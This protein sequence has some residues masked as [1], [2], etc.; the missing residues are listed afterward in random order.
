MPAA[1]AAGDFNGGALD[2]VT[3]NAGSNDFSFLSGNGDGTFAAATS[4]QIAG[5]QTLALADTPTDVAAGLLDAGSTPDLAVSGFT[6]NSGA[7]TILFG[8]GDTTFGSPMVRGV[9]G[10]L[11]SVVIGDFHSA[12]GNDIAVADA[13]NN[14]IAILLNDGAGVFGTPSTIAV[15][16]MPV[17]LLTANFD[18]GATLD[19]VAA[20]LDSNNFSV[21]LGN[22]DGTFA[23]AVA[24][25]IGQTNSISLADTPTDLAAGL[26][27]GDAN[28]DLVV[29]GFATLTGRVAVLLGNGDFTFDPAIN[30]IVGVRP[31]SLVLGDF[32][33][34]TLTDVALTDSAADRIRVLD[35][36]GDGS[37]GA[38]TSFGVGVMPTGIVAGLFDAGSVL[39]LAAVNTGGNN[40]SVALGNP[41]AA[42]GFAPATSTT[43]ASSAAVAIGFTPT[44]L[45][46][47]NLDDGSATDLAVV[48]FTGGTGRLGVFLGNGDT[49][50]AAPLVTDVG[51]RL[52]SVVIGDF[53]PDNKNDLAVTDADNNAILILLG[54][55]D[56][57][58]GFDAPSSYAVGA[59][60]VALVSG[61]FNTGSVLDLLAVNHGSGDVSAIFGNNDGTFR[62]LQNTS[63]NITLALGFTPMSLAAT[64]PDGAQVDFNG[65]DEFDLA[66]TGFSG[67]SGRLAIALGDGNGAFMLQ[68]PL[69][70]I[71]NSAQLSDVLIADFDS[72]GKADVAVT[73]SPNNPLSPDSS[74]NRINVL[75][76]NG[77]GT[78]DSPET[79]NVGG[80][81][82]GLVVASFNEKDDSAPDLAVVNTFDSSISIVLGS[83]TGKP[84]VA[85]GEFGSATTFDILRVMAGSDGG[86]ISKVTIVNDT[87]GYSIITGRGGDSPGPSSA[88]G[89]AITR[90]V[91]KAGTGD[92]TMLTG[93]GGISNRGIAE[94]GGNISKVSLT[95]AGSYTLRTGA[96]GFGVGSGGDGGNILSV[97]IDNATFTNT[98]KAISLTTGAGGVGQFGFGGD[99]GIVSKVTLRGSQDIGIVTGSGN[100]GLLGGGVAGEVKSVTATAFDDIFV[101]AGS[102]GAGTGA[103]S[104]EDVRDAD[105]GVGGTISRSTFEAVGTISLT[106]GT[107]GTGRTGGG[108]GG[109]VNDVTLRSGRSSNVTAGAGGVGD[110][111]GGNGGRVDRLTVLQAEDLIVIGGDGADASNAGGFGGDVT[112][113]TG[114]ITSGERSALV[115]GDGGSGSTGSH[116][117][118]VSSIEIVGNVLALLGGNGGQGGVIFPT[119]VL[120]GDFNADGKTDLLSVNNS[121]ST[122]SILFGSGKGSFGKST[123]LSVITDP[124][125]DDLPQPV[126]AASGDFNRDG[127]NDIAVANLGTDDLSI[128]LSRGKGKFD[129]PFTV[130]VGTAPDAIA[131]TDLNSDG[132]VDLAVANHDS[133][134]VTVLLG[135]GRGNFDQSASPG[136][137]AA[138]DFN[139]DTFTDL[140]VANSNLN[141][142]MLFLGNGSG[143]F[144]YERGLPVGA[145]PSALATGDFNADGKLDFAVANRGSDNV[146]VLL[147]NNDGTFAAPATF[148]VGDAPS[149]LVAGNFGGSAAPDLAVAN[150]GSDTV[151]I[152]INNG[153]GSF[154]SATHHAVG[155]NPVA[156]VAG[157]FDGDTRLDLATANDG[158]IATGLSVLHANASG[159]FDPPVSTLLAFDPLALTTGLLNADADLDLVV[160]GFQNTTGK[161]AVLLGA[162]GSTFDAPSI[163]DIG[164]RISSVALAD[165]NAD[166]FLDIVATNS[167]TNRAQ[168]LLGVGDGT[169]GMTTAFIV[170]S[171]PVGIVTGLF[172]ASTNVDIA[173]INANSNNFSVLLGNGNGTLG[174]ASNTTLFLSRSTVSVGNGPVDVQPGDFDGDGVLDL[175]TANDEADNISFLKGRGNGTFDAATNTALVT[176]A[177]ATDLT[178]A[179]VNDDDKLDAV[180][181]AFTETGGA[182]AGQ[183]EVFLGNGNGTFVAPS[184]VAIAG[185]GTPNQLIA[186]DVTG[187]G[188]P[189][190]AV[191]DPQVNN[192]VILRGDNTGAFETYTNGTVYV[193]RQPVSLAVADLNGDGR[194][195]V[196]TADQLDGKLSVALNVDGG[197]FQT[198]TAVALFRAPAGGAGGSVN[199]VEVLGTIGD[200]VD[201]DPVATATGDFNNDMAA[202]LVVIGSTGEVSVFFGDGQ[203]GFSLS[204]SLVAGANPVAVLVAD[205]T[206]DSRPD[207]VVA[208][209]DSD[210]VSIF[211]N[212]GNGGFSGPTNVAVGQA[213]TALVAGNFG[214]STALDL[215]VTVSG[216][217]AVTI[218]LNNGDGT[219]DL[220]PLAVATGD[221]NGDTFLDLLIANSQGN[222]LSLFLGEADGGFAFQSAI[223]TGEQPS[224]VV[225]GNFGGSAALDVAVVNRDDDNVSVLIGNGDGT[226]GPGTNFTVG[227][228]PVALVAGNFGGDARLDLAVLNSGADNVSILINDGLGSFGAATH[229]AAG[230]NPVAITTADLDADSDAD[231]AV[232]NSNSKTI[233]IL[234]GDGS[235]MFTAGTSVV[236]DD[237]PLAIAAGLLDD[238]G[239]VDLAV[240]GFTSTT[241]KLIVLLGNGNAT[242]ANPSVMDAGRRL[243][244]MTIAD[245][246]G[247]GVNDI[248]ATDSA[249]NQVQ[250]LLGDGDGGFDGAPVDVGSAPQAVVAGVF[251]TDGEMDLVAINQTND[252]FST[253]LGRGDGTFEPAVNT[254]IRGHSMFEIGPDPVAIVTG[255]L[256]GDTRLDLVTASGSASS[257]SVLLGD[258]KGGFGA[259][260]TIALANNLRGLAIGSLDIGT[261]LDLVVT[262]FA[263]GAGKLTV[264]LGN[265]DGTFGT[266]TTTNVGTNL[267]PVQ[268]DTFD[269]NTSLDVA[270][271]DGGQVSVLLGNGDGTFGLATSYNVGTTPVD[272]VTGT[273]NSDTNKDILTVN[274]GSQDTTALLGAGNGTFTMTATTRLSQYGF[275]FGR[276]GGIAAGL[277]GSSASLKAALNGS[278]T[279][280]EAA[281]IAAI[282]AGSGAT[283][284][285]ATSVDKIETTGSGITIGRDFN[286]NG[287]YN[288]VDQNPPGNGVPDL[289]DTPIDGFILAKA[290]GSINGQRLD[291]MSP[292]EELLFALIVQNDLNPNNDVRVGEYEAN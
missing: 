72:D 174:A 56:A 240:A 151:S 117:G 30:T 116:G 147:G 227:D 234:L 155:D 82:R 158:T 292:P 200:Y 239:T 29:S 130:N 266:P 64:L 42:S 78:F 224:G 223:A 65:D 22:G 94:D 92:V 5:S 95:G 9:G 73:V 43:I 186:G 127:N 291:P 267:G 57:A 257:L 274:A 16:T 264:L 153:S 236:L 183:V 150:S 208:N 192:F 96:G 199:G 41:D 171:T 194:L 7:L 283:P 18:G 176:G 217:D 242:Y 140:L 279:D 44:D 204:Q 232:A 142:V 52:S 86:A 93:D 45:A 97:T 120:S 11:T 262:G 238:G 27:D 287:E 58:S 172:D 160:T 137:V 62:G 212:N 167:S 76:G 270:V 59:E 32:N 80:N 40:F 221:V 280:I 149:A 67:S 14:Q 33:G 112:G 132:F 89:G 258:G 256:N 170:G 83:V 289:F 10:K 261:T 19:L 61:L 165:L 180:V 91:Q 220:A 250:V 198:P 285:A 278:V 8:N 23:T 54:N 98:E 13:T 179:D 101:N 55:P 226:F 34:D 154:G 49:T 143:G 71:G 195:D 6:A 230:D 268:L 63:V 104:D 277:A 122:I 146:S 190:L 260:T 129:E 229:F 187:D 265:G 133:N 244:A 26:L 106:A 255:D 48:G 193:G 3:V 2:L 119:F 17:A 175:L 259:A 181:S 188:I 215:A 246:D 51:G 166:T 35:G 269:A 271:I 1:L 168:V 68:Q 118:S 251:G 60:P 85:T 162:A 169:F 145:S 163:T 228:A 196:A 105:A 28:L 177:S 233:S 164:G 203:G 126:T 189:D 24:T 144:T 148:A 53:F 121:N 286:G 222:N 225:L 201:P 252:T 237:T 275:A 103:F 281:R 191:V 110:N 66:V 84:P 74:A 111:S 243:T 241:G 46:A 273:F 79:I 157:D 107:G 81:P 213:P 15:G 134:S 70:T 210:D 77:D 178:V 38:T 12:L 138:G 31:G 47:G 161:V 206:G 253:L 36:N 20:N 108:D 90:F 202:D 4:T 136:S 249:N 197:S 123:L 276:A 205:L 141:N 231:L 173:V 235:G 182:R 114:V 209:R 152:L 50:F 184:V 69:T 115:A 219:F 88:D 288:F 125:A 128:F 25:T 207:I 156:L 21:A 113:V 282:V 100:A 263:G 211:L 124:E 109:N 159:G 87:G 245:F 75:L 216:Q 290:I 131:A 39:D 284:D 272:L 37:F 218:L 254:D 185:S 248:A 135:D 139:D 102:G 214:G 99:G 247:D